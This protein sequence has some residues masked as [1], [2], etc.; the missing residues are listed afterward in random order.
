ME[1]ARDAFAFVFLRGDEFAAHFTRFFFK[2]VAVGDVHGN[3]EEQRG[4]AAL[5]GLDAASAG[6]PAERTVRKHDAKISMIAA[7]V[8]ERMLNGPAHK[9][10][11]LY[12]H[13]R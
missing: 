6:H 7:A 1:I 2:A 5:I 8:V 11:I 13:A 12:V 3:T 9:G 10:A 4:R